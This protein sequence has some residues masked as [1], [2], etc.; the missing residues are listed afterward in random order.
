VAVPRCPASS[1][2]AR[3]AILHTAAAISAN[4]SGGLTEGWSGQRMITEGHVGGPDQF[5]GDR[6]GGAYLAKA[7]VVIVPIRDLTFYGSWVPGPVVS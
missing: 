6:V 2:L 7:R 1:V 5:D 4:L 3:A